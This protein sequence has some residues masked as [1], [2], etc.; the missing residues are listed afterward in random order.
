MGEKE[1][2]NAVTKGREE[3]VRMCMWRNGANHRLIGRGLLA[4]GG[5]MRRGL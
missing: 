3:L 5:C 2:G 1:G 4:V